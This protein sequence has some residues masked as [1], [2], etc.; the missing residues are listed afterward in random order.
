M[1]SIMVP[2]DG[3]PL[4]ETALP[5]AEGLARKLSLEVVLVRAAH[6]A[7]VRTPF[8]AALLA[9]ESIDVDA[10]LEAQ[11]VDYLKNIAG[12]LR[13]KELKIRWTLLKGAPA[14]AIDEL[15]REIPQDMIVLATH[16]RTGMSRWMLGSVSEAVMS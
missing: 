8:S 5:Y 7:S 11:V 1:S 10:I 15:A 12:R 3:S 13:A 2:L 9:T 6:L 16:G 4:S 14:W